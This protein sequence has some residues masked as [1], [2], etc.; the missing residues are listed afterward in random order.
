MNPEFKFN[1][2]DT[3]FFARWWREQTEDMKARVRKFVE[4]G[5][6]SFMGSTWVMNDESLPEY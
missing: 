4:N 5:Q 6:F 2:S 3:N 1:W